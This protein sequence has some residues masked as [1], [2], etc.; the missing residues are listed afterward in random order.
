M[1]PHAK[2]RAEILKSIKKRVL[3]NH[4]NVAGVDYGA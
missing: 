1:T 3:A 2:Q 4:I